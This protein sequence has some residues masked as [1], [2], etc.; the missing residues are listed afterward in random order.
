MV[1]GPSLKWARVQEKKGADWHVL[2]SKTQISF[3]FLNLMIG[4]MI[5]EPI[6]DSH[7]RPA[8][9]R[10]LNGVSLACR[11]WRNIE[12]WL[13]SFA[14]FQRIRTSIDKEPYS[15]VIFQGDPDPLPPPTLDPRMNCDFLIH[16]MSQIMTF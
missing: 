1:A 7:T 6:Q 2:Q 12:N 5:Q 8:N 10:N 4:E 14:S 9:E 13:G 11:W 16:L 3:S 15:F